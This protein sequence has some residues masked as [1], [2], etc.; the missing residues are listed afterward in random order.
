IGAFAGATLT[1]PDFERHTADF[2]WT[3]GIARASW[4]TTKLITAG[5][6]LVLP[7]IGAGLVFQWW[8]QPYIAASITEPAFGL[9]APV[10]A[11][12]M[13]VNL[14]AAALVGTLA[15]SRIA[16]ALICL[17]CTLVTAWLNAVYLRPC[18]LPPA[19]AIKRPAPPGSLLLNW[20]VGK[21]DGQLLTGE[22]EQ[23]AG[24]IMARHNGWTNIVRALGRHHAASIQTYQ[25]ANRLWA[26]QAIETAGLLTIA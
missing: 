15:R 4:V 6:V 11:G 14:T 24:N 5:L 7:A 1:G 18:Y 17:V 3:Q 22:A 2:A 16:G 26:F 13:L 10:F 8:N 25:P 21:P 12:W 23:R 19:I 9:Y 20:D